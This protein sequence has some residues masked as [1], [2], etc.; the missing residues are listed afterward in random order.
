VNAVEAEA[1][2][3]KI[4]EA[5]WT[6]HMIVAAEADGQA[7]VRVMATIPP[8]R[9]MT[10]AVEVRRTSMG[11][12]WLAV[13][14]R[15]VRFATMEVDRLERHAADLDAR[16]AHAREKRQTIRGLLGE[17]G[18]AAHRLPIRRA[19]P[20]VPRAGAPRRAAKKSTRAVCEVLARLTNGTY[21][22]GVG[23]E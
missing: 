21:R 10:V 6:H 16:A 14:P 8:L 15:L 5:L 17:H 1:R 20:R 11:R 22:S 13:L 7:V 23:S 18:G 12:A 9:G 19:R 3:R 2:C 4:V